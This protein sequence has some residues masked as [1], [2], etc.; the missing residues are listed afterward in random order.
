MSAGLGAAGQVPLAHRE[1][2][3]QLAQALILLNMCSKRQ[4]KWEFTII[5]VSH[6]AAVEGLELPSKQHLSGGLE[7]FG[8]GPAAW[9]KPTRTLFFVSWLESREMLVRAEPNSIHPARLCTEILKIQILNRISVTLIHS[10]NVFV[11]QTIYQTFIYC[12]CMLNRGEG[13]K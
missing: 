3:Q 9:L 1:I 11:L 8:E 2:S 5:Q 13:L 4:T 10:L 7:E 6:I 12:L